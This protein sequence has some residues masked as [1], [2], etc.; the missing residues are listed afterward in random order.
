MPC[1]KSWCQPNVTTPARPSWCHHLG[2]AGSSATIQA[3][4][5][6]CPG[7]AIPLPPPDGSAGACKDPGDEPWWHLCLLWG[8]LVWVGSRADPAVFWRLQKSHV[9]KKAIG[10][11]CCLVC[12]I[13]SAASGRP[14]GTAIMSGDH[15]P[16][17]TSPGH[18]HAPST[19]TSPSLSD[20]RTGVR[21]TE[22]R[23]TLGTRTCQGH[24]GTLHTRGK[25]PGRNPEAT[26]WLHCPPP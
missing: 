20:T 12:D 15:V 26:T 8:Q 9:R 2:E 1:S 16:M 19:G 24:L 3:K 18:L 10:G 17:P 4:P 22:T 13:S 6:H 11:A 21:M 5:S 23:T 7:E 14:T 25:A